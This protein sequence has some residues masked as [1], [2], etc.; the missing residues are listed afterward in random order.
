MWLLLDKPVLPAQ[1]EIL[2]AKYERLG[3]MVQFLTY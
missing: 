3:F 1:A 2:K